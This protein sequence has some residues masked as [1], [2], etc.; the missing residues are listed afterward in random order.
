MYYKRSPST[1]PKKKVSLYQFCHSMKCPLSN[2]KIL[3]CIMFMY[4]CI[5]SIYSIHLVYYIIITVC[6]CHE[7]KRRKTNEVSLLEEG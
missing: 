1:C 2:G 5:L 4:I 6:D 7:R 3:K